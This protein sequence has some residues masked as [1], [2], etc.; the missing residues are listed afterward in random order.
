MYAIVSKSLFLVI[1]I[2]KQN[3]TTEGRGKLLILK[4][5]RRRSSN[6][7]RMRLSEHFGH[8]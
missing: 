7:V 4:T 2:T 3:G 6:L 1:I 5:G 8:Q